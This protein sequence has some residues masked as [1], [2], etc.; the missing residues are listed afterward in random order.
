MKKLVILLGLMVVHSN[1]MPDIAPAQIILKGIYANIPCEVQM[2]SEV[3][4]VALFPD[5]SIVTCTF[6]MYNHGAAIDLPVGFPVMNFYHWG[7]WNYQPSDKDHFTINVDGEQLNRDEIYVPEE[8][9]DIYA[10]YMKLHETDSIYQFKYDSINNHHG[11]ET[12]GFR[13]TYRSTKSM[14]IVEKELS[15]LNQW[16]DDNSFMDS[17]LWQEFD[18]ALANGNNLWYLWDVPFEKHA[19]R[20]IQVTYSV[21]AGLAYRNE[22]RYFKYLLSTGQGW[23]LDIEEARVNVQ[24][25]DIV[26]KRIEEISP[27]H[28]VL[29]PDQSTVNWTFENL[30]PTTEDDIYLRYYL[31]KERRRYNEMKRRRGW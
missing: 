10:K 11:V 26:P 13:T 20:T 8:M 28:G 30:E 16:K 1:V 14:E 21:P 7:L 5:S 6:N 15:K 24:L 27:S 25:H 18:S 12:R 4:D 31:P 17:Y 3:V 9:R 29:N 22:Y 2:V 23:H 19:R